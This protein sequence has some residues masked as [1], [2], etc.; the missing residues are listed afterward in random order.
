VAW[1]LSASLLSL[2]ADDAKRERFAALE[3]S[4]L[5]GIASRLIGRD[6]YGSNARLAEALRV[7]GAPAPDAI[8]EHVTHM[9]WCGWREARH[10]SG[11]Q[12]GP[13]A[14]LVDPSRLKEVHRRPAIL[15]VPMTLCMQDAAHVLQDLAG[16][17]P[18]IMY[19]EGLGDVTP[20]GMP[21]RLA[22]PGLAGLRE[23]LEVLDQDGLFAT[24]ADFVYGNH[25]QEPMT[26]FGRAHPVS[27]AFIGLLGR[28]GAVVLPLTCIRR[29]KCIEVH[30]RAPWPVGPDV[31]RAARVAGVSERLEQ[32]IGM[33]PSQWL[34]MATL[35]FESPQAVP[36]P[37]GDT[38]GRQDPATA[39]DRRDQRSRGESIGGVG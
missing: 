10:R 18:F 21:G 20:S 37:R 28:Q 11:Q 9:L 2:M 15:L 30:L 6:A 16:E 31:P 22:Q 17:R 5:A 12:A 8:N 3:E 25:R 13:E 36:E 35:T 39:S 29:D 24:F 4:D 32:L 34:L 23:I 7:A 19:G 14:I 1:G 26:L 27:S 38:D 33:A